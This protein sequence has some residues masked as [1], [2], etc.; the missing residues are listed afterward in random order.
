[1]SLFVALLDVCMCCGRTCVC[2]VGICACAFAPITSSIRPLCHL[3]QAMNIK[4]TS[5]LPQRRWTLYLIVVVLLWQNP[6]LIVT[7]L[8]RNPS[9]PLRIACSVLQGIGYVCVFVFVF[10]LFNFFLGFPNHS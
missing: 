1:M 2:C 10:F 4:F 9:Q 6:V 3:G 5:W 8:I 7:E